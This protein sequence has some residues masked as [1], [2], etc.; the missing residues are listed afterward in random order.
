MQSVRRRRLPAYQSFAFAQTMQNGKLILR[1]FLWDEKDIA[2]EQF[3]SKMN[4]T[5]E[6]KFEPNFKSDIE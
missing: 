3:S 1:N 6:S 2:S 5:G 4:R